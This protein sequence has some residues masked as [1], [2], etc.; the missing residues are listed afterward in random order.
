VNIILFG[1]G[2]FASL[3]WYCLTNDSDYVVSGFTVDRDFMDTPSKHG[4]PVVDFAAVEAHF[5]P[6]A[7]RMLLPIGPIGMN[8][9]RRGKYCVAKEK[10]Y[11]FAT[12]VSSSAFVWPD[13][14]IGECSMV[15]EGTVVQPFAKIG[16]NTLIRSGCHISHH[17]TIGDH[18][19]VA[20]Q[21]CLGGG[22]VIRDGCYI[23][24][25]AT[26]RD[27]VTVAERCLIAAGAVVLKDTEPDGVYI[28]VPARRKASSD[29]DSTIKTGVLKR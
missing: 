27:G 19:F 14:E 3:A 8:E 29:V 24:L 23:G 10:G 17:C 20:P 15:Y 12:Y 6:S 28:G 18:C 22:A 5:P 1:N 25:N 9:V 16:I 26:V 11:A 2:K 7:H 21:A 4:L 13:L